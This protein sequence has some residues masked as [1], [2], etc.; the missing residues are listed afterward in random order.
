MKL[1]ISILGF[2]LSNLLIFNALAQVGKTYPAMSGDNLL[3][4]NT[5]I[6]PKNGKVT[7]VALAYSE[8]SEEY[9]K[10]WRQ[11]LFDLFIQAPGTKL[12]DFEPYDANIKFVVLLTGLKKAVSGKVRSKMEDNVK[13]HWK[14]HIVIVKGKT[15][16]SYP[17]LDLGKG[18][19]DRKKPY[20]Y[21]LDK[22]G[23]IVW[24]T[25]GNYT[26]AKQQ[27]IENKLHELIGDNQFEDK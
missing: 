20:F 6:P 24:H 10:A 15:L 22:S 26:K 9:L 1:K 5:P 21:L 18:K 4:K 17:D 19:D 16:A 12:F 3:D 14:E 23:K 13:D 7:L 8:D 27:E 25:S 11:P 2:I